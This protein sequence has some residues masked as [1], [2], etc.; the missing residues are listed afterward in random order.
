M[1][2]ITDNTLD[3]TYDE[4]TYNVDMM[5]MAEFG[6]PSTL[7]QLRQINTAYEQGLSPDAAFSGIA[8]MVAERDDEFFDRYADILAAA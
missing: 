8:N 7:D 1:T 5:L 2:Y 6:E 3:M 4:Y